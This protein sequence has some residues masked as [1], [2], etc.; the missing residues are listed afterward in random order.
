MIFE[1][2]LSEMAP[3]EIVALM[4]ALLFE[5]KD[6]SEAKLVPRLEDV[7]HFSLRFFLFPFFFWSTPV[8][9]N[10]ISVRRVM[11]W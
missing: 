7:N 3:E 4:S 6:A 2:L 9:N 8:S 10:C 5:E 1:N 11:R